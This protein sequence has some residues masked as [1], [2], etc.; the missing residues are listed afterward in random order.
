MPGIGIGYLSSNSAQSTN[1]QERE[2]HKASTHSKK[3]K[4][5]DIDN[6]T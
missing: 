1:K 3:A 5:K 4:K 2:R 6:E